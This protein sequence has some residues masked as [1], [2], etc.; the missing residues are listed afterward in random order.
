MKAQPTV[1]QASIRAGIISVA[2]SQLHAARESLTRAKAPQA[3][4]K[5]RLAIKSAEGAHRHA[6]GQ[7]SR[8]KWGAR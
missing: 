8:A 3:L 2:I 6:L 4:A 1:T 5:V 7:Y